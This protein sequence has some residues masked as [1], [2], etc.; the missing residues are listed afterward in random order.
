VDAGAFLG[1]GS[2]QASVAV[3]DVTA[4][5][6]STVNPMLMT[7]HTTSGVF[8][9]S[10]AAASQAMNSCVDST[11]AGH[12]WLDAEGSGAPGGAQVA[13]DFSSGNLAIVATDLNGSVF[14]GSPGLLSNDF[15]VAINN[16]NAG[17]LIYFDNNGYNNFNLQSDINGQ[18]FGNLGV[19]PTTIVTAA[20]GYQ[21][22]Q[23]GGQFDVSLAT[24]ATAPANSAFDNTAALKVLLGGIPGYE[25]IMYG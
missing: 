3:T 14:Q 15:Y 1:A 7:S 4:M 20:S 11:V 23:N 8:D 2:G 12:S 5:N 9:T 21:I 19:A 16:F 13:V 18:T 10:F 6:F 17:D 22:G 24:T 25:P